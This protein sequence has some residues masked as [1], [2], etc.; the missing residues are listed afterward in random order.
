[1]LA[2][3]G[4]TEDLRLSPS[5]RLLA[6]AGFCTDRLIVFKLEVDGSRGA[7]D[8]RITDYFQFGSAAMSHP[9][10][11]VFFDEQTLAV[12]NRT[13]KVSFFRLPPMGGEEKSFMLRPLHVLRGGPFNKLHSPGSLEQTI[14]VTHL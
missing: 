1:M 12:A 4:R 13:G 9:H 5:K 8:I 3:L 10:G 2:Q 14:P 6:I 11:I 7:P